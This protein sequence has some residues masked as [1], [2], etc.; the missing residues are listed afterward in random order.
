MAAANDDDVE[1]GHAIN[2]PMAGFR[3]KVGP[4]V[5]RETLAAIRAEDGAMFRVKHRR[6]IRDAMFHVKHRGVE[7]S[8]LNVS[9]ETSA[10]RRPENA[11]LQ[12]N[13]MH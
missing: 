11:N 5:S 10:G 9:R 8:R 13:P 2:L 3:V 4:D 12:N 1:F 6:Q 7:S